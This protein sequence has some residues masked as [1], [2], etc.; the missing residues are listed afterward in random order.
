MKCE[1][2]VLDAWQVSQQV[3]RRKSL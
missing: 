3:L 2:D 1:D